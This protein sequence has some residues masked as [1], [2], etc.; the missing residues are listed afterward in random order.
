MIYGSEIFK[1]LFYYFESFTWL[2]PAG[3]QEDFSVTASITEVHKKREKRAAHNEDSAPNR[4]IILNCVEKLEETGPSTANLVLGGL[5]S[6]H[7]YIYEIYIQLK[8]RHLICTL[9]EV[10]EVKA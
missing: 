6:V 1:R 3:V 4:N 10:H 9:H 7:L 2:E 5:K 8:K